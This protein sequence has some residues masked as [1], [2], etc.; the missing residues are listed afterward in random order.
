V[1]KVLSREEAICWPPDRPLKVVAGA[2]TGKTRFLVDRFVHLVKEARVPPD[3]ILGLTFTRKAAQELEERLRERLGD[4]AEYAALHVST[5]DSFWLQILLEHPA[6]SG[7]EQ[8]VNILDDGLS[9]LLQWRIVREIA[10]GCPELSLAS[11]HHMNLVDL[12]RAVAAARKVTDSAKLRLI[13]REQ[14]VDVL[15]ELR[16]RAF[17]N[18]S[19]HDLALDTIGFIEGVARIEERLLAESG[20]LDYGYILVQAHRLLAHNA[21]IQD[22]FKKKFRHIL[23]DEA[24]DTNFGQFALIKFIAA[25]GLSNV[26]VVGDARQSIFGFRDADPQSLQDYQATVCNL[27]KNF[28]SYQ[29]MLDLAVE[30]EE[31]EILCA[32]V[33]RA[34]DNGIPPGD[35]AILA[36]ARSTLVDLEDMLRLRNIPTVSLVGGFY[37]RPEVLDARAYLAYLLDANDRGALVRILER[38]PQSLSLAEI[39]DAVGQSNERRFSDSIGTSSH[40]KEIHRIS[41][42]REEIQREGISL[43]LRWFGYLERADYFST[44]VSQNECERLRA[45]A[46]LRKLF[47]LAHQLTMPPVSLSDHD[48]LNYIDFNIEAGEG[49]VEASYDGADGVVLTTIHRA[50]GLEFP[51]VIYCGVHDKVIQRPPGFFVHLRTRYA[52]GD[53]RYGGMGLLL[54]EDFRDTR[55]TAAPDEAYKQEAKAEEKRLDYVALTRA[56][57]LQVVSAHTKARGQLPQVLE[58]LKELAEHSPVRYY[59]SS[60]PNAETLADFLPVSTPDEFPKPVMPARTPERHWVSTEKPVLRW[61][62]SDFEREYCRQQGI[63]TGVTDGADARAPEDAMLRG[64]IIHE[65]IRLADETNDWEPVL[66]A[67]NSSSRFATSEIQD[68]QNTIRRSLSRDAQAFT[69]HPFELLVEAP[70]FSLWLRG[71]IDRLEIQHGNGRLLDFKTGRWNDEAAARAERQL[72]FYAIAWRKGLWPE[73]KELSLSIV[74]L[75]AMRV[76]DM[77][78]NPDFE[79]TVVETARNTLRLNHNLRA[80]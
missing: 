1:S 42:L 10:Q 15:W 80:E 3:R 26:T 2:G 35:I 72:N 48:V 74:H 4:T 30:K 39:C 43:A 56:K 47:E 38:G 57:D 53:W 59:F 31:N 62:F 58:I 21:T 34:I 9:A 64:T 29:A 24:Q 23:I 6:E 28:R 40:G 65:A 50:K 52:S 63:V 7:I 71:V 68:W 79:E 19:N 73:V 77:A 33:R 44:L 69:E 54:P 11:F 75:D 49:E 55:G 61:S 46:N 70:D 27:G 66:C 45:Q 37:Q 76:I 12:T 41:E 13:G 32:L 22:R 5:F 25:N 78:L 20:A 8:P 67:W 14:L 16:H 51:I 17:P 36:R 60:D 18:D